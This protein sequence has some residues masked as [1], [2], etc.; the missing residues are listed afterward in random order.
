MAYTA[1]ELKGVY[2]MMPAF[3]TPDA[4]DITNTMTVDVEYLH[5]AVDSVIRD[6]VQ[7]IA[8]MSGSGEGWNL[9]WPEFQVLVKETLAAVDNRVPVFFGCLSANPRETVQKIQ[10][11]KDAGGQGVL[12]GLPYYHQL[13]TPNVIAYY[14][15]MGKLFPD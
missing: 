6:G 4:D 9:L 12:L 10:F 14:E 13:T 7:L 3:E 2:A 8:T 5:D 11:V 15:T 1:D